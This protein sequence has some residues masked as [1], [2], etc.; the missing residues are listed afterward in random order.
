MRGDFLAKS[1]RY[2]ESVSEYVRQRR[3][4]VVEYLT[5][6][7]RFVRNGVDGVV[8]RAQAAG[9][10]QVNRRNITNDAT[11]YR[12]A[13]RYYCGSPE[14]RNAVQGLLMRGAPETTALKLLLADGFSHAEDFA[15][16]SPITRDAGVIAMTGENVDRVVPA[17]G[18]AHPLTPE[19]A[20][21]FLSSH[22]KQLMEQCAAL[23]AENEQLLHD[24][25][26]LTAL[27]EECER[28]IE[29]LR[30]ENEG[31]LLLQLEDLASK[32]P[33]FPDLFT[34]VS[35]IKAKKELTGVSLVKSLPET[36]A[37][38]RNA[39]VTYDETF[40]RQFERS[41]LDVQE[42]TRKALSI[43]F[44]QGQQHHSLR[45]KRPNGVLPGIPAGAFVSRVN[46]EWRFAWSYSDHI[47]RIH[48]LFKRGDRTYYTR[49]R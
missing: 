28:R 33:Q 46:G 34:V 42:S 40:L 38:H 12:V 29:A 49:E 5:R 22:L 9:L 43:L 19:S 26:S 25:T 47:V 6:D 17:S 31:L 36:S 4:F 16:E 15:S 35:G 2:R 24:R 10:K 3:A 7:Y 14:D 45:T 23:K 39:R 1:Q 41:I 21:A 30:A 32:L 44:D 48:A 37:K 27:H 18:E 11:A 8:A 20:L 13:Y